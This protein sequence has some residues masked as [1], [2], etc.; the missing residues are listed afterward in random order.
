[1][2]YQANDIKRLLIKANRALG[3]GA[4]LPDLVYWVPCPGSRYENESE[5]V[6]HVYECPDVVSQGEHCYKVVLDAR[7]RDGEFLAQVDP[8]FMG[9][10]GGH[11][12]NVVGY[13]D[14]WLYRNRCEA[15]ETTATMKGGFILHNSWR[16][17]GHSVPYLMGLRSEEQEAVTC[18]NHLS[19]GSWVPADYDCVLKAVNS[20][21]TNE[22]VLECASV[23]R[24]RGRGQTKGAD[25]LRCKGGKLCDTSLVYVIEGDK[26]GAA[27]VSLLSSGLNQIGLL[28]INFAAKTVERVSL[29][30]LPYWA[31]ASAFAPLNSTAAPWVANE[32]DS[33]GY[34]MLPYQ[35]MEN[36]NRINWDLL[37]NFRVF[38]FE[39][40]FENRSYLNHPDSKAYNTELLKKS[41]RTIKKTQFDGPIPFDM[42]Y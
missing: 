1:M 26:S 20:G 38:D 19:S 12:M 40:E 41:T 13:N 31:L 42:V 29:K 34:W 24:I 18:P 28:A 6:N 7:D 35:T 27:N 10:L 11:A 37:D 17:D 23:K 8:V 25:M 5:C 15:K 3:I 39:V 16:G 30:E 36:M 9:E 22:S 33:C 32:W 4:P 21:L 2:A 14:N